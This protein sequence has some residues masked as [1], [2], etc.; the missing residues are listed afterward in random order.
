[1]AE[2]VGAG[3]MAG[4]MVARMRNVVMFRHSWNV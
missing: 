3:P 1:M 4:M 2:E